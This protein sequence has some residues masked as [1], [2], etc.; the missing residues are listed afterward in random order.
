MLNV[1]AHFFVP[2]YSNN[3]KAKLIHSSSLTFLIVFLLIFQFAIKYIPTT[4]KV[5]EVLGYAANIS[6]SEVIRLT[7]QKRAENGLPP[8]TENSTLDRAALAKGTDMLN[9]GYWAHVAPDGTQPWAFFVS[10]GY[11]YR[12]A[13]EN[14]ARDFTNP[15]S[16]V[17]AWMASPSHRENLLSPKYKEIGIGVVE[18]SLAGADTTL[19]VQFFGTKMVDTLPI[20]PIAKVN[21]QEPPAT[22]KAA[23]IATQK[24]IIAEVKPNIS[25]VPA[26]LSNSANISNTS[27]VN[28][29]RGVSIAIA[30]VLITVVLVDG[31]VMH[32]RNISR[33]GGKHFAH[34]A[35][36]AIIL[37][38][39]IIFKA[40]AIL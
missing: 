16:A 23:P 35:Y 34:F 1:L 29:S 26:N 10:F 27:L 30:A 14:L 20:A 21:A 6:P 31:F 32:A 22:P 18:G 28:L 9:K 15:S 37:V 3:H 17:D 36:L 12:Y 4:T 7:N 11:N 33:S 19:V 2:R 5:G 40:G 38:I 39:I 24:P 13:G 25:P 8:L